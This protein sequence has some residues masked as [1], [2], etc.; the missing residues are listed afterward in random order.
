MNALPLE[1]PEEMDLDF[2]FSPFIKWGN[3]G[4]WKMFRLMGIP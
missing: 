4:C 1:R 2:R 3:A